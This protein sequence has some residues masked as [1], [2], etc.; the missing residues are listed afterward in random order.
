MK[1]SNRWFQIAL[2]NLFIL[3]IMGFLLRYKIAFSIPIIDQKNLLHSHSHFAFSG[4]VGL[5]LMS[6][7]LSILSK[8]NGI[9]LFKVF[10]KHLLFTLLCSWGMLISF[11]LQGYGVMS[12]SFSTLFIFVNYSYII[13]LWKYLKF[14]GESKL[15]SFCFKAGLLANAL[16]SLGAFSLAYFMASHIVDQKLYLAAVYF[17]LHFQYNGYFILTCVGFLC[18]FLKDFVQGNGAL[19]LAILL[20][21]FA[22]IPAYFLS[23]LWMNIP[24]WIYVFVV[25]SALCQVFALVILLKEIR[26]IHSNFNLKLSFFDKWMLYLSG[27]AFCTKILLQASSTI[28]SLSQYAFGFRPIVIGY[29]HLV[30]LGVVTIYT[31]YAITK[32][33]S[34]KVSL[35]FQ[36]GIYVFSIGIVLNE[37]LLM[38]QGATAMDYIVMPYTNE[39]LLGVAVIMLTGLAISLRGLTSGKPQ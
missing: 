23:A 26:L 31:I 16:S 15:S 36:K 9:D 17:Y 13:Q 34:I 18:Y 30:L 20:L 14:K 38:I 27:T 11:L 6:V 8:I 28:P 32:Q 22:Q 1:S 3:A 37:L 5:A 24:F 39:L 33:Y 12:I 25:A 10:W 21:V 4:W 35:L 7:Q 2:F 19:R 29:L